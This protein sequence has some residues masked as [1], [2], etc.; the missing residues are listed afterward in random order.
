MQLPKPNT[1]QN[2]RGATVLPSR[3]LGDGGIEMRS[4]GSFSASLG[5]MR[6]LFFFLAT[7]QGDWICRWKYPLGFCM[8]P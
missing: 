2:R 1:S 6:R 3:H 5:Y 7:G 4:S 8:E